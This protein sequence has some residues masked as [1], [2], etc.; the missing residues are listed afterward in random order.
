MTRHLLEQADVDLAAFAAKPRVVLAFDFDGT[1]SPIAAT[2]EAARIDEEADSALRRLLAEGDPGIRIG[3]AS[4]RTI[5][6]LR[7]LVPRVHFLIGLHG[8][9]VAPEGGEARARFDTRESDAAIERLRRRTAEFTREGARIE[10]KGHTLALHVR[11]LSPERAASALATFAEAVHRERRSGAPIAPLYGRAVIEARPDVAGKHLAIDE[12]RRSFDGTLAF[13]G[14][15]ATDEE[16][17]RA[18]PDALNVA[19]MDPVRETAA[20]YFLRSPRETAAM[21]RR[22]SALRSVAMRR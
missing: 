12:V 19:V 16:V 13:V 5:E 9:E 20:K 17:F 14:D 11:G 7:R 2:P 21:I 4:G 6:V 3:I 22:F 10:D 15:D 8:L 18:F 1:L